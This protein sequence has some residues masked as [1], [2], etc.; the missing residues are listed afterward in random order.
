MII[1]KLAVISLFIYF[2]AKGITKASEDKLI[3]AEKKLKN[4]ENYAKE[5]FQK[6]QAEKT[7]LTTT[8]TELRDEIKVLKNGLR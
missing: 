1:L 5:Q 7:I 3:A 8:I 2:F 6:L 4:Y